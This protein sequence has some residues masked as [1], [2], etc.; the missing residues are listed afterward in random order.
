MAD[1]NLL[2]T[3]NVL[4]EEG[5]VARA[6]GR[7]K[8]SASAM[9]RALARLREATGDPLLVRAGRRLVPTPRALELRGQI[10]PL[11]RDVEAVLRPAAAL[12]PALIERTFTLRC[13]DGMVEKF[14]PLL[15][16]RIRKEAPHVRLHFTQRTSRDSS[17]LREGTVDLE[18]GV[19]SRTTGP[20]VRSQALFRDRF[21][22]AVRSGNALARQKVTLK[23][24]QNAEHVLVLRGAGRGPVDDALDKISVKRSIAATVESFSAALALARGSDLVAT[25]P[26]RLTGGLRDGLH[27]FPLPFRLAEITVSLLWHPRMDGDLAHRWLRTCVREVCAA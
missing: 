15:L 8:L 3:L 18:T 13:G 22:G 25:V 6:A 7:L 20:E 10:P 24:Y 23:R 4:L 11:V 21:V 26:E 1:F 27:S 12:E 14:G 19:V 16:A 5:S 2:L 9:S 17:L